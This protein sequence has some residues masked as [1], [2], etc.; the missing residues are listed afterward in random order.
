MFLS[1]KPNDVKQYIKQYIKPSQVALSLGLLSCT[2]IT[3]A[4]FADDL[5]IS[6]YIEGSSNNKAIELY[7]PTESDIDLT[8][9][10]LQFYFNGNTTSGTSIDLVGQVQ[11]GATFVLADNDASSEILDKAQQTSTSSFFNGDDAIV[12]LNQSEI[13][14]SLGQVGVDP[15]SQWGEG[16]LS[17]KDNT[18][19]RDHD[20]VVADVVVDDEVTLA[21]WF[22]FAQNDFSDLGNFNGSVT[23]PTD[24]TDPVDPVELI[25]G[26][27]AIAIHA[28]QGATDISPL[29]GETVVVEAIVTADMQAG[30][31][32][33]YL[34]M[35]DAESDADPMTSEGIFVYTENASIAV[36][37][38]DR[39]R[40]QA[41]VKE[42]NNLTELADVSAWT[43]CQTQQNLPTLAMVTLPTLEGVGLEPYEGMRV[44]FEQSLV[45]NSVSNLGKYGEAQLGSSRHFI[46]TQIMSPGANALAL[47]ASYQYDRVILDDG[48]TASNPDVVPYPA[49]QL[50]ATNTL[51]AGDS[52]SSLTGVLHYGFNEYR[53]MPTEMVNVVSTNSRTVSPERSLAAD[54]TIA[55]YNVLNY[56]N[57]DGAGQGFP[58]SRGADSV[59]EFERQQA[60]IVSA[61]LNIDADIVG[62]MEIENDGFGANSAI[63]TLVAELNAAVGEAKYQFISATNSIIGTDQI[64]VGLLYQADK[65]SPVGEAKI[66]SSAN[67][68]LDENGAVFFDSSKNRPMLAQVFVDDASGESF[69]VAVNH[70]KSK[71]GSCSSIGDP[72]M[73]DGQGNCNVTRTRAAQGLA[74]WLAQEFTDNGEELKALVIGDLNAYAK[75]DPITALKQA[76]YIEL[77]EHTGQSNAYSYLYNGKAGQVDHALANSALI[78]HVLNVSEWHINADEPVVIDYNEENKSQA[79]LSDYYQADAYRSSDHDPMIV[80]LQF[81]PSNQA[82]IA[83]FTWALQGG[84]VNVVSTST[85]D[86]DEQLTHEWS[87][88][89]GATSSGNVAGYEYSSNGTYTITLTVTDSQGLLSSKSQVVEV[90]DLI[91]N[92]PPVA[93][94]RH[95]DLWFVD[96]FISFSTDEDGYI[97]SQQWLFN[98]GHV[99]NRRLVLKRAG[100]ANSVQLTVTDNQGAT[101]SQS[102]AF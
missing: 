37:A 15:G 96:L 19:R 52:V 75:E 26:E 20:G 44:R 77:F 82:P 10:Q 50:S 6:E 91:E 59:S 100:T 97:T 95:I 69:V 76:G 40:L 13:I 98:D 74:I 51:R 70:L 81:L 84:V 41:E 43:I 79:Q 53:V 29:L 1:A 18:L 23:D 93:N 72:D 56:F 47:E 54:V 65:V 60:K 3:S 48:K 83:D 67:S 27:T 35:A 94:I 58:T 45:V 4:S 14:D 90:V 99:V 68:P 55:S 21:N 28:I 92:I 2:A 39:V 64:A 11:A 32:G 88:G 34:Q 36:N 78:E 73:N 49:P 85:D 33:F 30:L 62:L 101:D 16:E 42:Y 7:N 63:S 46:G 5:I 17:T 102:T 24:P 38:G 22:G 89:D 8:G 80:E 31:K 61:L 66:L 12:L 57:G 87:W 71:G 86:N 25:C 9:Y